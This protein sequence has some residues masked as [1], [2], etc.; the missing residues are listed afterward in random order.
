MPRKPSVRHMLRLC[1][2]LILMGCNGKKEAPLNIATAA[3]M[4]F[5][6]EALLMEFR[7]ETGISCDMILGSSGKLTAQIREGAPFDVFVSAE[8]KYAEEIYKNGMAYAPPSVYASGRLV[9]WS[10]D[11]GIVP[12]V[13][14]L[15]SEKINHIALANPRIAPY[16]TAAI[17]VLEAYGIYTQVA[18]KLVFGESIAQTNQFLISK[19]AEIGFTAKSVVLSDQMSG[20]GKWVELN[21]SLYTRISQGVVLIR[22]KNGNTDKARRFYDFLF[23]AKAR[24]ILQKFGYLVDKE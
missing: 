12:S 3:N 14:I 22:T 24:S 11:D 2:V 9:L 21:D 20:V 23:S 19:S 6:M 18:D 1:L 13:E 5:A 17:E 7:N 16:G 4:Q 10:L 15:T 8:M